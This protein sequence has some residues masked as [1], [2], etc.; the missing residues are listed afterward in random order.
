M[1]TYVTHS[2]QVALAK[3]YLPERKIRVGILLIAGA[4]SD[5]DSSAA[6]D[7]A[8]IHSGHTPLRRRAQL[9]TRL[10]EK[11]LRIADVSE[12]I[13]RYGHEYAVVAFREW[14]AVQG[15][16]EELIAVAKQAGCQTIWEFGHE[17]PAACVEAISSDV[18]LR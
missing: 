15:H 4:L 8:L 13:A 2:A 6:V 5:P 18:V 9:Q 1:A 10:G 12:F 3:A 16:E 11:E 17:N 14:P 7:K